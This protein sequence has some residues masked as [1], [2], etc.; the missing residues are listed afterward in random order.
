M[1]FLKRPLGHRFALIAFVAALLLPAPQ[2]TLAQDSNV[3]NATKPVVVVSLG[4]LQKL[5]QDVN[6]MS[7]VVGYPQGGFLFGMFAETYAKDLDQTQPLGILVPMVDQAP[8]PIA[9]IP[10]PDVKQVL[11]KVEIQTGPADEL[12]DGT[13]VISYNA[14]TVY[15]RQVGNWAVLASEKRYLDLAPA[16]PSSAF[17]GMGNNFDIAFKVRVQ[18][19]P[20]QLRSVFVGQLRQ[21]LEQAMAQQN[22]GD[23]EQARKTAEAQFAQLEQIIEKTDELTFGV[24]IDQSERHLLIE[25]IF[26][27]IPGSELA[28]VYGGQRP[29]ASKFASVIR[30]DAAVYYHTATSVP[31]EGV[32]QTREAVQTYLQ[33]FEQQIAGM[34]DLTGKQRD[35]LTAMTKEIADLAVASIEE[36]KADL[37]ALLLAD[38]SDFRFVAGCFVA[39]G[40]EAAAIVKEISERLKDETDSPEFK[41]DLSEYKGVTMHL[42]EAEVPEDQ[43]EMRRAFGEKLQVHI[44]T[45]AKAVYVAVGDQSVDLLK[46]LIDSADND[47]LQARPI[48]QIR[49][50]P[51]PLLQYI[52]SIESN[53]VVSAMIDALSRAG[54]TGELM[55]TSDT[56][57]NG[58]RS[59]ITIGEGIIQSIGA[60]IRQ[61]QQAQFQQQF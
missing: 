8:Q 45:G 51:L 17:T 27:A 35:D 58:A 55:I 59:Q 61:G 44:G 21:G 1:G 20:E 25:T 54:D 48:G 31:P 47:T 56:V 3:L 7:G 11:K 9:L 30:D 13:L 40:N 19:I 6:Y 41:F 2:P 24:N 46:E 33:A 60:A 18:E 43:D 39:D 49:V 15:I 26:K 32:E 16:D 29:I 42:V 4:S 38:E 37:G 36:G 5:K 53:D 57:D 28:V 52:Q 23:A 50:S 12:E 10:T 34:G 14:N 22:P